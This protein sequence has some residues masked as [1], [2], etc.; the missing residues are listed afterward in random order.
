[1]AGQGFEDADLGS[2]T[3]N[4]NEAAEA[5]EA[6]EVEGQTFKGWDKAFDHV[7]EDMTVTAVYE[8][9]GPGTVVESTQP[10][11]FSIQK[12]LR[13]GVIYIERNGKTYDTT[14]QLIQ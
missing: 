2:Q 14:G 12:V 10:S 6:P 13:D 1:M 11:A 5:P 4:W 7:T 3:V 8:K 9:K